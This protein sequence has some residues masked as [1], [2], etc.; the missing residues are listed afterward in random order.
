[1]KET[2]HSLLELIRN[3]QPGNAETNAQYGGM[4]LIPIPVSNNHQNR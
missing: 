1:M 3:L 2:I 4:Q